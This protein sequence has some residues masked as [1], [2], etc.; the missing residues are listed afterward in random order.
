M[1]NGHDREIRRPGF[2]WVRL[3]HNPPEIAC[4]QGGEWVLCGDEK[5]WLPDAVE[6]ISERL[7]LGPKLVVV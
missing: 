3:G 6:V 1:L 5:P 2:Y 4:W 7:A